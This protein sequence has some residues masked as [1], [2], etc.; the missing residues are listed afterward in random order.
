MP[1]YRSMALRPIHRIKHVVDTQG[2]VDTTQSVSDLIVAVD[3]PVIGT[4]NQV[5][6]GSTVHGIYLKVEASHTSGTGLPNFYMLI[7]KNPGANLSVSQADAVGGTDEKRFVIHQ[8]MVMLSGDAGNGL[9]R[10]VFNGVIKIP[11]GYKRFGPKDKLQLAIKT[12]TTNLNADWCQQCH[13]K[14]FR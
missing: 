7:Y 12:G 14:E 10:V 6:T 9:P 8:E 13:Y 11:K 2:N 1:R 5:E 3:A 4:V